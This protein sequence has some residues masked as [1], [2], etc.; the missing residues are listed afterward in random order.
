MLKALTKKMVFIFRGLFWGNIY[1]VDLDNF[2][3]KSRALDKAEITSIWL[4]GNRYAILK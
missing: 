2:S 3:A 1:L 4:L